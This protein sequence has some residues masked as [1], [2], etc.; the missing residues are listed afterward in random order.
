MAKEKAGTRNR[1]GIKFQIQSKISASITVVMLMVMILVVGLVYDLIINANSTEV[2][3]DSEAVA[4]QVEK[5]FAP[6]ERMAEQLALDSDVIELC[7]TTVK[8]QRMNE[9]PNYDTVLKKIA[10]L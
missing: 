3:Q 9:N 5:F 2:Q 7:S 4:L 10:Q 6:F 1:K 8:G